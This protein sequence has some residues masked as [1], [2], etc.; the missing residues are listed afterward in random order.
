MAERDRN[1]A[2]FQA[3]RHR[4]CIANGAAGGVGISLHDIHGTHPRSAFHLPG[5]DT[6]V[7]KQLLGRVWRQGGTKSIQRILYAAGTVE[8]L[9]ADRMDERLRNL[10]L[11]NDGI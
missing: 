5:E 11:F 1:H 6:R 8:E 10:D 4:V 9:M 3:N 2:A 7:M